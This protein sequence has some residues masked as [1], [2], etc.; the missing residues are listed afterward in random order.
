MDTGSE[1]VVT[2][3]PTMTDTTQ[4]PG[5]SNEPCLDNPASRSDLINSVSQL[6]SSVG[7]AMKNSSS[8][9][10]G[11][12]AIEDVLAQLESTDENFHR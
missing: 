4:L 11:G 9:N 12:V 8:T 10:L 2:S 6:V 7:S 3:D 1:G 5:P